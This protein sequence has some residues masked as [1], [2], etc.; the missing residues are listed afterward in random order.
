MT[1]SEAAKLVGKAENTIRNYIKVGKLL[2]EKDNGHLEVSREELL[3]V[4]EMNSTDLN[5]TANLQQQIETQKKQL[6][7]GTPKATHRELMEEV[8]QR[9]AI[10]KSMMLSG[11]MDKKH[12]IGRRS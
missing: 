8:V 12:G 10:L 9:H 5:L 2:A 11:K 7:C 6:L 3:R 1:I 4:F